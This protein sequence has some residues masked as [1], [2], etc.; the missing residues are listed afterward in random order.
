MSKSLNHGVQNKLIYVKLNNLFCKIL[1]IIL[2]NS[3]TF[4]TFI[5]ILILL[6]MGE[7]NKILCLPISIMQM[8]V[9]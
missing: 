2:G 7:E 9:Y 4:K 8:W 6:Y 5:L 1:G 3:A